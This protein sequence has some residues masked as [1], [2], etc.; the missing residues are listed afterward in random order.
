M[1][2]RDEFQQLIQEENWWK[3][4]RK[5]AIEQTGE[6]IFNKHLSEGA[7]CDWIWMTMTWDN[8]LEGREYWDDIHTYWIRRIEQAHLSRIGRDIS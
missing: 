3:L 8:T 7:I 4:F 1:I 6:K 5:R 2:T